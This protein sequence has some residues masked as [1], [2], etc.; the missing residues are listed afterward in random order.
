M[1]QPWAIELNIGSKGQLDQDLFKVQVS[2]YTQVPWTYRYH[3]IL[4][5]IESCGSCGWDCHK[6]HIQGGVV[7]LLPRF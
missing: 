2:G 7:M 5:N 4:A 6:K 3:G 1:S